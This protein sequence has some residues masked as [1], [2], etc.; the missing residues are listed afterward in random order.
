MKKLIKAHE[1]KGA[2]VKANEKPDG[3]IPGYLLEREEVNRTKILSNMVK[4]KRKEKAGKWQ[5]P[6]SQVKPMTEEEMFKVIKSGKRKRKEWKR[7]ITQATFV[8]SNFTRKPPKYERYIRPM[9]MRFKK[10]HVTHP[11]LKTTF[12]PVSYTHLTLPTNREV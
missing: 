2:E 12:Y 3:A 4:Q 6:I 5:V 9:G 10:A 7:M 8:G 1:E 11:E